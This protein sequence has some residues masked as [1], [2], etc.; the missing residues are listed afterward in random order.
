MRLTGYGGPQETYSRNDQT[1][2]EWSVTKSE[3]FED[4]WK[5]VVSTIPDDFSEY[6]RRA[7]S[8]G[9]RTM[10]AVEVREN[11]DDGWGIVDSASSPFPS[12]S[13]LKQVQYATE[14]ADLKAKAIELAHINVNGASM[15]SYNDRTV[16]LSMSEALSQSLAEDPDGA[17]LTSHSI[18]LPS[19]SSEAEGSN[20]R[21]GSLGSLEL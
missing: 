7:S 9:C 19:V 17:P 11:E 3:G 1:H 21:H 4:I 13:P 18:E 12:P 10:L 20:H 8:S 16:R 6:R 15:P 14:S 2:G 5:A